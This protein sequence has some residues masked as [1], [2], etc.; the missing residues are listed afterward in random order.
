MFQIFH[1]LSCVHPHTHSHKQVPSNFSPLSDSFRSGRDRSF[2]LHALQQAITSSP[3]SSS[4]VGQNTKSSSHT[5]VHTHTAEELKQVQDRLLRLVSAYTKHKELRQLEAKPFENDERLQNQIIE[6]IEKQFFETN[7]FDG[8]QH[9]LDRLPD[10]LDVGFLVNERQNLDRQLQVVSRKVSTLIVQH[11]SLYEQGLQ[12]ANRLQQSLTGAIETCG[13]GRQRL[14]TARQ[15]L[16]H[17]SLTIVANY[18]KRELLRRLLNEILAIKSLQDQE[19]LLKDLIDFDE[20]FASAIRLCLQCERAASQLDP[21]KCVA[22]LTDRLQRIVELIEQQMS[23]ALAKM[24]DS[25]SAETYERLQ[26]SYQTL[27]KRPIALD[28][29]LM[30]FVC[31]VHDR[32]FSI[33]YGY[34]QLFSGRPGSGGNELLHKKSNLDQLCRQLTN[35]SFLPCL[36]DLNKSFYQLM[37]NYRRIVAWH[38]CNLP[39]DDAD[40]DEQKKLFLDREFVQQKLTHGSKRIWQEMEQKL[41]TLISLHDL[42]SYSLDDLISVLRSVSLVKNIGAEFCSLASPELEETLKKATANYFHLF[43]RN[44]MEELRVYMETEMWALF[45]VRKSFS[46][47][48]LHDFKLL[49]DR[50]RFTRRVFTSPSKQAAGGGPGMTDSKADV[51]FSSTLLDCKETAMN[52]FEL[53]SDESESMILNQLS[54]DGSSADDTDSLDHHGHHSQSKEPFWCLAPSIDSQSNEL[55]TTAS[56]SQ[57]QSFFISPLAEDERVPIVT[58]STINMMRIIGKYMQIMCMLSQISFDVLLCI[59]QLFDFYLYGV[60]AFFGRE[61]H[62]LSPASVS[63]PFKSILSRIETNLIQE[64]AT[65]ANKIRYHL[66]QLNELVRTNLERRECLFSLAERAIAVESLLV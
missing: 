11:K 43:H 17:T 16:T 54:A 26:Q 56:E 21:Y 60:Y 2:S 38:E 3:S 19:N 10:Q 27:G 12:Q 45:P 47:K 52:F 5:A 51:Y 6:S 62:Q 32:T 46:M 44:K 36:T 48:Q 15:N 57:D 20:D 30:H 28:Q 34:V 42:S 37:L 14:K 64:F 49:E 4:A 7:E 24:C 8:G 55:Q 22:S 41:R 66:P 35:D 25:F 18:S 58:N 59:F 39:D 65:D 23:L 40:N 9:V 61:M 29:L 31:T 63:A 50:N 53:E 1:L 33:V 13:D